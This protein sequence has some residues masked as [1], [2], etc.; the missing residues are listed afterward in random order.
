MSDEEV[1]PA[2][3]LARFKPSVRRTLGV[4]VNLDYR[5]R[6]LSEIE[7]LTDDEELLVNP[8]RVRDLLSKT[9]DSA[10]GEAGTKAVRDY[11]FG[12]RSG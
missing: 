2:R 4:S 7:E 11:R 6:T 1:E 10:E 8:L 5:T 9:R 12:A 3:R